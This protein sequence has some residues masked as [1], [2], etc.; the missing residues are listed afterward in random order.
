[1]NKLIQILIGYI[2]EQARQIILVSGGGD[3][4]FEFV[5]ASRE[6]LQKILDHFLEVG[7]ITIQVNGENI[8]VPV[9]LLDEVS[10]NP[11]GIKSGCC[12]DAHLT[13]VRNSLPYFFALIP[14]DKLENRSISSSTTLIG[15]TKLPEGQKWSEHPFIKNL[16]RT[17][18]ES[19]G[20]KL[21]DFKD[22]IDHI[23]KDA[24]TLDEHLNDRVWQWRILEVLFNIGH[25]NN[26]KYDE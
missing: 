12:D 15:V 23:L 21:E 3:A 8:I 16:I 11:E 2:E 26:E 9:Y 5:G 10:V 20:F 7:G 25:P 19:M 6:I 4:R 24:E 17:A 13:N 18:L 1:M 22:C 14:L